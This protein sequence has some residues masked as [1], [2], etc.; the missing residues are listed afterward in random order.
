M[1]YTTIDDPTAYFQ[2]KLYTGNGSTNA[3]TFDGNT[4]MQPDWVWIKDRDTVQHHRLADSVRGVKKN[5][6]SDTSDA[7][8]TPD[9]NN[10][11]QSFDS[12][13]FTLTQDSSDHGYNASGSSQVS[14]N[15]LAGGSASS[16][17]NGSITSSVSANTTAGFSI[18]TYTGNG[19][20]GATIGHGLST[21]AP[22]VVLI[23]KRSAADAWTMLNTNVDLNKYMRLDDNSAQVSDPMFNNTAPTTS[24]FTVDA[25]GQ[26]NGN[27]NTFV[28][29]CFSEVK[30]YS[31]FGKYVGNASTNGPFIY[32]GFSPA[33]V[34][35]KAIDA[36]KSWYMYDDKRPGYNTTQT[37]SEALLADTND[38]EFDSNVD[39]L[40]NGF[41]IRTSGS[42]ENSSGTNYAYFAFA[43]HPIVTSSGSVA[44]AR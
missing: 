24:V 22:K 23:K 39:L 16:N 44:P 1:A 12:N 13:G 10:G 30:G 7:E 42:G 28:A 21:T 26:V 38:S 20:S 5:L 31:K 17:S 14:W 43:K 32:T 37:N 15:W 2:V 4:N 9:S 25:D 40:S 3:I 29:Y 11:L 18:V 34:M 36:A 35:I 33:W 41:K 6:K 27:T 8:N 19:V